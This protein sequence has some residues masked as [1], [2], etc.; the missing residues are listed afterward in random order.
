MR[1]RPTTPPA[2]SAAGAVLELEGVGKAFPGTTVLHGIDLRIDEGEL[3][4]I[5]GPSGS[6]KTTLLS[7][8]GTLEPPSAGTVR[9]RGV[10]V[11]GLPDRR[12]A[13]LRA[14]TIGFVFQHFFLLPGRSARDNVADGLLYAGHPERERRRRAEH[15]LERVGL[16]H[17]MDH[18]P[19]QLSGGERQRVAVA[20]AVVGEPA[21]VLADEPTGNLD[22]ATGASLLDLLGELHAG[23]TTIAIVTHDLDVAAAAPRRVEVRDGRV[24]ADDRRTS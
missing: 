15:A 24:V 19:S 6:G 17:R 13:A 8:L 16:A 10:A 12:L 5:V 20:R 9:V 23:G 1:R 14:R 18:R 2:P 7:I 21:V 3:V 4:A 11:D 22:T